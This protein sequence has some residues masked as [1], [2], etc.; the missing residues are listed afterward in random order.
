MNRETELKEKIKKLEDQLKPLKN[1]LNTIWNDQA[2]DANKRIELAI[3]GRGDFKPD[4]LVFSAYTKCQCGKGLAYPKNISPFGAW[5]CSDILMG[6]ASTGNE[7]KI[8]DRNFPFNLYE[9]TSE[10]QPSA[11]G[12][13]TRPV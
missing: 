5:Y 4:E 11:K 9:I 8:H 10:Y 2:N 13:T 3:K 6:L 1:E 7:S 12:Q